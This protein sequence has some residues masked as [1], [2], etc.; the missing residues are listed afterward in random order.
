MDAMKI[1]VLALLL[2]GCATPE[3]RA[4][5]IEAQYRPF[6]EKFGLSVGTPDYV[7]CLVDMYN[8]DAG[9]AASKDMTNAI[10][11]QDERARRRY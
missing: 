10:R 1:A 2:A 3:E 4:A 5:K 8:G 7:K 9:R 11:M 6:C